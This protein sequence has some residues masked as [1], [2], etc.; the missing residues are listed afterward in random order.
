MLKLLTIALPRLITRVDLSL[1]IKSVDVY[2]AFIEMWF[3]REMWK[4]LIQFN[5]IAPT[6]NRINGYFSIAQQLSQAMFEQGVT[7]IQATEFHTH[8]GQSLLAG[9]PLVQQ[10]GNMSFIHKSVQEYFTAR[11]W[12]SALTTNE[13]QIL[14][15]ARLASSETGLLRFVAE[16]YDHS[17][18]LPLTKLVLASQAAKGQPTISTA[19]ANA[20]TILNAT[21]FS[22]SGMD[23]SGIDI[24]GA[25]LDNA[26]MDKTNLSGSNLT[27]VSFRQAWL[28][29]ANLSNATLSLA[30]FGQQADIILPEICC[31]VINTKGGFV[32][33]TV[34]GRL[35]E[36]NNRSTKIRTTTERVISAASYNNVLYLGTIEG[37]IVA[38]DLL[39]EEPA[40]H[41][42]NTGSGR[43][44]S[45]AVSEK[46]IISGGS[47]HTI[48]VW[49]RFNGTFVTRLRG[50]TQRVCSIAVQGDKIFS[51]S[52]DNSIR[53]WDLKT[54]TQCNKIDHF[55]SV[56]CLLMTEGRIISGSD[57]GTIHI[58]ESSTGALIGDLLGHTSNV[59]CLAFFDGKIISGSVDSNVL[60]WDMAT[61][62]TIEVMMVYCP[63]VSL[64]MWN[65]KVVVGCDNKKVQV[66]DFASKPRLQKDKS[67]STMDTVKSISVAEGTITIARETTIQIIDA[68]THSKVVV[69]LMHSQ[70]VRCMVQD[71]NSTLSWG[72]E[73]MSWASATGQVQTRISVPQLDVEFM[74]VYGDT[75]VAAGWSGLYLIPLNS[76]P[77]L[78]APP[79]L[80]DT[81]ILAISVDQLTG[82]IA[83]MATTKIDLLDITTGN[84]LGELSLDRGLTCIKCSEGKLLLAIRFAPEV[85]VWDLTTRTRTA[86]L[87]G[88]ST[89]VIQMATFG[90][91]MASTDGKSIR[92]WHISTGQCLFHLNFFDEEIQSIAISALWLV[93][94][95][96]G[97]F[98]KRFVKWWRM[99]EVACRIYLV[100]VDPD[101]WPLKLRECNVKGV[102][103]KFAYYDF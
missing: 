67:T 21:Q 41:R 47:D 13:A 22:F 79:P 18:H 89:K 56:Q 15:G 82:I 80:L 65:G 24:Q 2:K 78:A 55:G 19:A 23:F 84:N 42:I 90:G 61:Y 4:Q 7:L 38:W 73:F 64:L 93:A 50:H 86:S 49:N 95:C 66:W 54:F 6:E 3:E 87:I 48:S 44:L 76:E 59:T 40:F 30:S 97:D 43:V 99:D 58:W 27:E 1:H 25:I 5:G 91:R 77:V 69:P 94:I 14:L 36:H 68:L 70:E 100:G 16:L 34:H 72:G 39:E 101:M 98:K 81:P 85:E 83:Y 53:I 62:K 45:I 63:V 74:E 92:V 103:G 102:L 51:G 71:H 10:Q 96:E 17:L 46:Y 31:S 26:M 33:I 60:V 57:R 9:L 20:I 88:H 52:A 11:G 37:T 32:A 8:P 75:I 28:E 35:H 12:V 29:G